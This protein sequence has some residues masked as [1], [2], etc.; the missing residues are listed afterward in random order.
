MREQ[1][2]EPGVVIFY[3]PPMPADVARRVA[4]G[5][6]QA[7]VGEVRARQLRT[8]GDAPRAER[9]LSAAIDMFME[10]GMR[11]DLAHAEQLRL[12]KP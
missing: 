9:Y 4:E 5:T 6:E 8:L 3:Q 7:S 12:N 10:M 11:H 2:P 1:R